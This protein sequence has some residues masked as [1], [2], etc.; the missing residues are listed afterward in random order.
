MVDHTS[1]MQ[2]LRVWD[3][4]TFHLIN[5]V[6]AN[7]WLDIILPIAREKTIWLPLYFLIA[8]IWVRNYRWKGFYLILILGASVGLS[9]LIS[10]HIIKVYFHRL[11]PC[12]DINFIKHFIPRVNCGSGFSFISSHASNHFTIGSFF[13]LWLRKVKPSIEP[14][15]YFWAGM[16]AYAQVYVGVHY[17]LDVLAGSLLGL[18]I[19][20]SIGYF[21]L[22]LIDFK[23]RQIN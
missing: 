8:Y 6:W 17:P 2:N 11:R 14:I 5:E 22:R 4:K 12:Q 3:I 20:W 7:P 1:F 15:P 13:A 9:D 21:A 19:G 10:A 18:L 16:I 23:P